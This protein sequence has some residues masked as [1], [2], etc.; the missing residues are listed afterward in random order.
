[1]KLRYLPICLF[2]VSMCYAATGQNNV[3]LLNVFYHRLNLTSTS[4][5]TDI[6]F[7]YRESL[8]K[9]FVGSPYLNKDWKN[10]LVIS[11]DGSSY[12]VKGRYR[13][14]NDEL[15]ILENGKVKA[16][17]PHLLQGVILGK[18]A[19]IP[20]KIAT[21]S[22]VNYAFFEILVDGD[23][24]LLKQY[25]IEV[26]ESKDGFLKVKSKE[27]NYYYLKE[28]NLAKPLILK[29]DE[30]MEMM[31]LKYEKVLDIA[32][33]TDDRN[34]NSLVQLFEALKEL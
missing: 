11:K 10:G 29:K 28:D 23:I 34:E 5:T 15:Q 30:I 27:H 31:P 14:F 4:N 20:A 18:K 13:I 7:L 2:F 19:F 24:K 12:A 17:Y 32:K 21:P 25:E 16:L 26:K 9:K 8:D 33:K 3:S 6:L 1:M 22:G